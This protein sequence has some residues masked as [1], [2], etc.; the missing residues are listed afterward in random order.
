MNKELFQFNIKDIINSFKLLPKIF[1]LLWSLR[2]SSVILII[3]INLVNSFIPIFSLLVTQLLV[4]IVQISI[5]KEFKAVIFPLILYLIITFIGYI[6][7]QV[8]SYLESVFIIE[9]AYD[10]NVLILEKSKMLGLSDFENS[11][12]YDKLRR[13]Q[14]EGVNSPYKTFS[15]ILYS[16]SQFILLFFSLVIL[17]YWKSWIVL[18]IMI[19]PIILTISMVK[20]G[21]LQYK[22]EYERAYRRRKSWYFQYIMT[23]DITFKEIKLYKL[24]E[25]FID[26]YKKLNKQFIYEDKRIIKK[27]IITLIAFG[28]LD[29]LISAFMIFLIIVDVFTGKIFIGSALTYIK[30]LNNVNNNIQVILGSVSELYQNN[31]YVSQL[32][33]FLELPIRLLGENKNS[34]YIEEIQS[35][36]FKNVSFRYPN[37]IDYALKNISFKINKGE[38][39]A[40]VGENGSGKSTLI[41]LISGFYDNYE[42]KI[43]INSMPLEN[44]NME[45]LNNK[46]GIIFQDFNKY[47]L[48]CRE[49][50]ALSQL[51]LL[52]N[53]EAIKNSIDK[54]CADEIINKLPKGLDSQL[55]V[56]FAEGVQLS[57]GQWQKIAISRAFLRNADCYILD[58]PSASLD[59][60]AEKEIFQRSKVLMKDKIGIF[61]SHRL[62]NLKYITSRILVLKDGFLIQ[63]GT[64]KELIN[65]EGH[66]KYLYEL[67]NSNDILE[68]FNL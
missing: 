43:F 7:S 14:S 35:I 65:L 31:L 33:E 44:I 38:T 36:E 42:G 28:A 19:N 26:N 24:G 5:G 17:L 47:E 57:L 37:R 4:N 30:S 22:I 39:I 50:I 29:K 11:D 20:I 55:G 52:K 53:D 6:V 18:I 25:Y 48:S 8:K 49:N 21:H 45:S 66:Y 40:L 64:H 60:I 32:F 2:K 59:P 58:E 51:E 23:N 16:V 61:I 3:V 54:A 10:I 56:W 46:L 67:Q 13:A 27:R 62:Y 68:E 12:I 41:K 63:E 34:K 9:L 1:K 15:I